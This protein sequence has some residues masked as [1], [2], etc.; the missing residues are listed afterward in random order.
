MPKKSKRGPK[1][2]GPKLD[3]NSRLASVPTTVRR[4]ISEYL[5]PTE[6]RNG[7]GQ[8]NMSSYSWDM[9]RAHRDF[10]EVVSQKSKPKYGTWDNRRTGIFKYYSEDELD[11]KVDEE[12]QKR[13]ASA[14]K[15]IAKH[16]A[17]YMWLTDGFGEDIIYPVA[18]DDRYQMHREAEREAQVY[19]HKLMDIG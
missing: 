11:R 10:K 9:T 2:I 7:P 12:R 19:A 14:A 8:D 13:D 16:R 6:Y 4:K 5:G 15:Y 17:E 18:R 1:S 3:S